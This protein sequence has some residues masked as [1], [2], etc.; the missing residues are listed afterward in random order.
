MDGLMTT[1]NVLDR[2][3]L[4]DMLRREGAAAVLAELAWLLAEADL[5]KLLLERQAGPEGER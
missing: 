5:T 3:C 1:L 4:A 2:Q